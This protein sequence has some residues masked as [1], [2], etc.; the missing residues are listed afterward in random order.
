MPRVLPSKP[1][2]NGSIESFNGRLRDECLNVEIFRS[3][4]EVKG[5]L[6]A[7]RQDCNQHRPHSALGD[8]TPMEFAYRHSRGLSPSL[9]VD[10][11][12][13]LVIK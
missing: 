9:R 1:T 10:R 8:L 7:W 12:G 2:E 5:K 11:P 13:E 3:M 6:V 4:D